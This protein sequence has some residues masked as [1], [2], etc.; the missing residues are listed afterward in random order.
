MILVEALLCQVLGAEGESNEINE[1]ELKSLKSKR[2]PD[3][4]SAVWRKENTGGVKKEIHFITFIYIC[5]CIYISWKHKHE[6][7]ECVEFCI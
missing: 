3:N 5:I 7:L 4:V 6:L 1:I 2:I